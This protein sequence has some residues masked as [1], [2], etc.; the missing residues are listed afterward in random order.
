MK[1]LITL[2]LLFTLTLFYSIPTQAYSLDGNDIPLVQNKNLFDSTNLESGGISGLTGAKVVNANGIRTIV[3][4]SILPSTTYRFSLLAP[5][6]DNIIFYYYDVNDVYLGSASRSL[7]GTNGAAFTTPANAATYHLALFNFN[8]PAPS[9]SNNYQLELGS[10]ATSF[11]PYGFLT[12]NQIFRDSNLIINGD[13][14][15]GLNNWSFLNATGSVINGQA[16]FTASAFDGRIETDL[17]SLINNNNYYYR[18]DVKT[19]SNLVQT[20]LA[21]LGAL[22]HSGSGFFESFSNVLN[23]TPPSQTN[24]FLVRDQRTSGF[25]NIIVDNAFVINLSNINLN[26]N[27]QSIDYYYYLWRQNNAYIEGYNNGYTNGYNDGYTDGFDLGY[28]EGFDDGVASDTSFAVGYALGLSQGADMET[29]SSLLILIVALIG[30]ILMI[31]GFITKRGIFNLLSTGAFIVLG[32][33]LV[34]FVGFIIIAIGLV[35]INI[36]YAFFGNL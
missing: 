15:N 10:V 9:F 2:L 30:F 7:L 6:N 5:V 29:G 1:K 26:L 11:T 17:I 21:G 14:N 33:L 24:I 31:I 13:F 12:L 25:N 34:E 20:S 36:Y 4:N 27:T 28:D 19:T 32:G 8:S 22:F 18:F 16:N 23:W 3:K 35:L